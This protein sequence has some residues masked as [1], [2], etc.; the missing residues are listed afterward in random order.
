M[1]ATADLPLFSQPVEPIEPAIR[2]MV[3][4]DD[5]TTSVRAARSVV[6]GI[7]ALQRQV[8]EV[9]AAAGAAGVTDGEL[10]ALPAFGKFAY[11]TVRKRR[12]ELYQGG[13][14]EVVGERDGFKVWA[15]RSDAPTAQGDR[16]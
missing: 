3:R 15:V 6:R 1:M 2:G 12:T 16:A 7:S 14:L 4:R 5:P 13:Y 10:E 11:S 8:L 9:I